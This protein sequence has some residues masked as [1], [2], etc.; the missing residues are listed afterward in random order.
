MSLNYYSSIKYK[1]HAESI[2][3]K[4]YKIDRGKNYENAIAIFSNV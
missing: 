1:F 3:T 4:K 2:N